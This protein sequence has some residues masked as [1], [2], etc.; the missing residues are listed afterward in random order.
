MKT[1]LFHGPS[2][3]GKDTQVELLVA[4]YDFVNIGTGEMFRTMYKEGD[5]EGNK[6]YLSWSKGHFVPNELVYS[7]L[8]KWVKRFETDKHW[9]FVSVVRDPGQIEM[10]DNLLSENGRTLDNVVHFTLSEEHAIERMSLRRICPYCDTTY[11]IKYKREKVE[12]Y[13]DRCGMKL[14]QRE[15]DQPEKIALR[16]KE[17]NRT[18]APILETYKQR[19]VLIEIDATPSIEEIH[20]QVV[21][22]LGL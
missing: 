15:D 17:Y 7:M 5:I 19:G 18:I 20:T 10:F 8:N 14:V 13:C 1:I 9:A 3:S 6:A 11:H 21:T 16:L 22:K 2:G 4:K 12:G